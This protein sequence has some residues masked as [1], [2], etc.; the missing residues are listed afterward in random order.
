M[1]TLSLKISKPYKYTN[2]ET[3]A[4]MATWTVTG[5]QEA[6][7][8]LYADQCKKANREVSKD[9][10]GNPIFRLN[11]ETAYK[12]GVTNTISRVEIEGKGAWI[13][14]NNAL[15]KLEESLLN[16]ANTSDEEKEDI[17]AEQRARKSE[18]KAAVAKNTTARTQAWIAK[19]PAQK[20][21]DPFTNIQQG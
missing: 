15:I 7:D 5:S 3:G 18:F 8:V 10:L 16:A 2:K 12:Y 14:E 6:M 20:V 9:E 11:F 17:K 13:A 1:A 19:Q 4:V 21:N